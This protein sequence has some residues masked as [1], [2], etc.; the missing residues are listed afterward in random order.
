MRFT[1]TFFPLKCPQL[2]GR[3][4]PMGENPIGTSCH[5]FEAG[6]VTEHT[7]TD[8]NYTSSNVTL[9]A[10]EYNKNERLYGPAS[11][12]DKTLIYTCDL[13]KCRIKC[14]CKL[15]TKKSNFYSD[16]DDHVMFHRASHSLCKFCANVHSHI[17]SYSH[18]IVYETVYYPGMIP[19]FERIWYTKMG[20]ASLFHH[21]YNIRNP[22]K[23]D[24]TFS[25]DKCDKTFKAMSHL[26]RH[27]VGV[28][29][30]KKIEC[31]HCGQQISR[32]DNLKAHLL[33]AHG[34]VKEVKYQCEDCHES[35]AK[36]SNFERHTSNVKTNCSICL[37]IFCSLKQLQ[38]HK[39]RTHPKYQCTNCKKSFHN[40]VNLDRHCQGSITSDG[41]FINKCEVCSQECCSLLELR[42]HMTV[43][44][45]NDLQCTY[46]KKGFT[47]K[48]GLLN[49][50]TKREDHIC[51]K[52]GELFCYGQ[53][54]KLHNRSVHN[55]KLIEVE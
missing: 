18:T 38:Q 54:L 29:F 12:R 17:P 51:S 9:V 16:I 26:K 15:C 1:A 49:H 6:E 30:R 39:L 31:S 36:K 23:M 2:N 33:L 41:A 3:S 10:G 50:V 4:V 11:L 53:D 48:H 40:K 20:S 13:F 14:P 43:H 34:D 46:C 47:S 19:Q 42:Q 44:Q 27:E 37:E 24:S 32:K 21:T 35:F 28:H 55:V 25:C 45:K 22:S 8:Y 5:D 7:L 52:C